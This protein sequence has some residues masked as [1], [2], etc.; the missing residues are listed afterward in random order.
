MQHTFLIA[1]SV[2]CSR[3]SINLHKQG[4][5]SRLLMSFGQDEDGEVDKFVAARRLDQRQS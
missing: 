1:V 4:Q 2:A 3:K 5:F